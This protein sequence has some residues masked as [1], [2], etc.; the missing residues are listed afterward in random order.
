MS[1]CT[2]DKTTKQVLDDCE[3]YL[4]SCRTSRDLSLAECFRWLA[5]LKD[6]AIREEQDRLDGKPSITALRGVE[7]KGHIFFQ[8]IEPRC[9]QHEK[10]VGRD[11]CHSPRPVVASASSWRCCCR[12]GCIDYLKYVEVP[13]QHTRKRLPSPDREQP[14]SPGPDGDPAAR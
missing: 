3:A 13:H 7:R 4:D 11:H 8:C 6:V 5:R 14:G 1:Y 12:E 2:A 9:L 10:W